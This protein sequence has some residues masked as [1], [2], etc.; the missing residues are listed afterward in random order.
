MEPIPKTDRAGEKKCRSGQSRSPSRAGLGEAYEP[1]VQPVPRMEPS[2]A[3]YWSQTIPDP[4]E[5]GPVLSA[6]P[7][8]R[9]AQPRRV[10]EMRRLCGED[11]RHDPI[12]MP[13]PQSHREWL[14]LGNAGRRQMRL[15][16]LPFAVAAHAQHAARQHHHRHTGPAI[17]PAGGTATAVMI[18]LFPVSL[19]PHLRSDGL[20]CSPL[21]IAAALRLSG[22]TPSSRCG[23]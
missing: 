14:G 6:Q 15:W 23:A 7:I 16:I 19:A 10:A 9:C 21:R 18:L 5:Q 4:E 3:S 13:G 2:P 17:S 1:M 12:S 22:N 8:W 11:E 20:W